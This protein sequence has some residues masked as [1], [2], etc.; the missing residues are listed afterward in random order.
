M[1]GSALPLVALRPKWT[2]ARPW[3]EVSIRSSRR[4]GTPF[5]VGP[6][7]TCC[8]A[9]RCSLGRGYLGVLWSVFGR[10]RRGW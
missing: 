6:S 10:V 3:W 8:E 1:P 4:E 9:L 5:V 7:L 2:E